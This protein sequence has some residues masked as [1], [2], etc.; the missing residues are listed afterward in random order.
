MTFVSPRTQNLDEEQRSLS[1]EMKDKLIYISQVSLKM[2]VFIPAKDNLPI[3]KMNYPMCLCFLNK[4]L[5]A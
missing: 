5:K 4:E 1:E 2:A 3:N